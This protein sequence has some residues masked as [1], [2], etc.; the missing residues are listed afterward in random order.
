[1][2]PKPSP[3]L[4]FVLDRNF[5][6]VIVEHAYYIGSGG[7]WIGGSRSLAYGERL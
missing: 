7:C 4:K 3:A 5:S 1:M 2:E 6:S